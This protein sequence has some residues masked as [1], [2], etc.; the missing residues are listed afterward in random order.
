MLS[1]QKDDEKK[2]LEKTLYNGA[3]YGQTIVIQTDEIKDLFMQVL[4]ETLRQKY[5]LSLS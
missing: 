4:Q 2:K 1:V 5:Q 3:W